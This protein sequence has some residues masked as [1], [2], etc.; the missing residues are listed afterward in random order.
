MSPLHSRLDRRFLPSVDELLRLAD[1]RA[2]GYA[3]ADPFPHGV[4]DG[5]F[6]PAVLE[7]VA[8][9]MPPRSA[10]GW[11]TWETLEEWKYVF[12]RPEFFGPAARQLHEELNSSEF[13]RFLERLTGI[14]G[15]IPD[16]H[17]TAAGYFDIER[18][19]FLN[20]HLDFTHNPKLNL[21]R[22]INVLLYLNP[23]WEP[24]WGGQLELWRSL[25]EGPVVEIV[26]LMN[27]M[28]IFTTPGAAHGHP[29]KITAPGGRSRLCFSAYYFTSPDAPDSPATSHG[30]LFSD[31]PASSRRALQLARQLLPPVVV[32]AGRAGLRQL[33]RRVP[34]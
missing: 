30:V 18:G 17:L 32:D 20:V 10:P 11:T 22:R 34:S 27:R 21:V 1:E 19:G 6:D 26:P 14:A 2:S 4:F 8:A 5:L 12:D 31:R 9:E 15:L 29:K 25:T 7:Q 23:D 28:A 24:A 16:P 3:A 13:V 33:R